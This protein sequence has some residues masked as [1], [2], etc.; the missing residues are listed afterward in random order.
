MKLDYNDRMAFMAGVEREIKHAKDVIDG[1][2]ENAKTQ[3]DANN[4]ADIVHQSIADLH[5]KL[6]EIHTSNRS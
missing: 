4:I 1:Y 5:D 2:L 6:Q 3:E